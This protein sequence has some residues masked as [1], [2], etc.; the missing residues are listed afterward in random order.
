MVP[1][2]ILPDGKEKSLFPLRNKP[3]LDMVRPKR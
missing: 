3:F 2:F 1:S